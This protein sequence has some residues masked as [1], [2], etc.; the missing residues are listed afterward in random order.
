MASP[1]CD[2]SSVSVGAVYWASGPGINSATCSDASATEDQVACFSNSASFLTMLAPGVSIN[3]AGIT[4][5]GT[6]QATPFV[7]GAFAA[8]RGAFPTATVDALVARATSSGRSVR[9]ARN[10]VS[11][12]RLD[13]AAALSGS[14]PPSTT[15][16]PSAPAPAPATPGPVGTVTLAG[17]ATVTKS[18]VISVSAPAKNAKTICLSESETCTAWKSYAATQSFTLSAGD[19][20]KT[21]RVWWKDAA[22]NATI[23]PVQASILL[24]QTAPTGG[25][26]SGVQAGKKLLWQFPGVSD[27]GSGVSSYKLLVSDKAMP[28][29]R[30]S[31]GTASYSG[32]SASASVTA[33]TKAGTYNVR[34]CTA[35]KA[36][37]WSTG[38]T[39]QFT[40][41]VVARR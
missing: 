31:K 15:P 33:P 9:D 29:E 16:T 22:G 6:S 40:V 21:V 38:L 1:G 3:A 27:A 11:K 26:L 37:N 34:L 8:L 20:T 2:P 10:G 14:P 19:G 13:L 24:D 25:S 36:G 35:D 5:S 12:P 41:T 4:M 39:A 32:K 7:A 23:T 18:T 30:C 28:V 17:K